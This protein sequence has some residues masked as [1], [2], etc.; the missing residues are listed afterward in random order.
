MDF[1]LTILI[2][3]V[4]V[5]LIFV[6]NIFLDGKGSSKAEAVFADILEREFKV[7]D[8]DQAIEK[9]LK[10]AY[11]ALAK[12]D[13]VEVSRIYADLVDKFYEL[14]DDPAI[15]GAGSTVGFS[16]SIRKKLESI[17]EYEELFNPS[18][19]IEEF[20]GTTS[21]SNI[22]LGDDWVRF[23][24]EIF[25]IQATTTIDVFAEGE[26][27]ISY[28]SRASLTSAALGVALPGPAV[29][30]ALA[31]PKTERHVDDDREAA[32]LILGDN[33]EME[34]QIEPDRLKG[35]RS[36]ARSF[37]RQIERQG[38]AKASEVKPKAGKKSDKP[39]SKTSLA[40]LVEMYEAGLI[41][42]DEFLDL[43]SKL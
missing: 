31:R 6:A 40:K 29:V 16:Q 15:K 18:E 37:Q 8:V 43:K 12:R 24:G 32:I 39:T 22:Y 17:P 27:R 2:V 33:Y 23:R 28:T 42:E 38:G 4:T 3:I 34:I 35:A 5:I 25:P 41:T 10:P 7:R 20:F 21:G 1:G 9:G 13:F 19:P 26:K 11:K 36:F 14:M 30:Y